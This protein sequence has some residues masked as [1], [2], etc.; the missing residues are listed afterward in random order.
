MF[1][2][3]I[4]A[5]MF[6]SFPKYAGC[7]IV[8]GKPVFFTPVTQF[9]FHY[10]FYLLSSQFYSSIHIW[11]RDGC[12][13]SF[14]S[15]LVN[16]TDD[17]AASYFPFYSLIFTSFFPNT[18]STTLPDIGLKT[19]STLIKKFFP[20][21]IPFICNDELPTEIADIRPGILSI[22]M[23]GKGTLFTAAT[24]ANYRHYC[25]SQGAYFEY[26]AEAT[27]RMVALSFQIKLLSG[28]Q[29]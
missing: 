16:A 18:T 9:A 22:S 28:N 26:I 25:I 6:E 27:Q 11:V 19:W 13:E 29:K 4:P 23:A 1:N 8:T 24:M 20:L 7:I 5:V 12:I 10:S 2:N 21:S 14:N 3:K 15:V 17:L